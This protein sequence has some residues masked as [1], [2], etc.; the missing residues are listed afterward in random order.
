[1]ALMIPNINRKFFIR[2]R[3]INL[4]H[5]TLFSRPQTC[6]CFVYYLYPE[7]VGWFV[8]FASLV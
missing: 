7:P 2:L 6:P 1:M 8:N 4:P 3:R 5:K